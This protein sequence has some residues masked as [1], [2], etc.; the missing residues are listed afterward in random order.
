MTPNRRVARPNDGG[1]F[2]TG[3]VFAVM[4]VAFVAEAA[5]GWSFRLSQLAI[6]GPVLLIV[7]GLGVLAR[8]L[9]PSRA[10]S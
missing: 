4:G 5:G 2:I 6:A 1:A 7:V 8:A 3:L 9:L 10:A